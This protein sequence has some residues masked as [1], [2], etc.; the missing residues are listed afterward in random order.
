MSLLDDMKAQVAKVL[1]NQQIATKL[2]AKSLQTAT[3]KCALFS[4]IGESLPI[5]LK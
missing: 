2:S 1:E 3:Q 4:T 5:W